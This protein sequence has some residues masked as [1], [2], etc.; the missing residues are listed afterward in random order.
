[1]R[2]SLIPRWSN[3]TCDCGLESAN[4]RF[5]RYPLH[6]DRRNLSSSSKK[7]VGWKTAWATLSIFGE[8]TRS[9]STRHDKLVGLQMDEQF[10][11][12]RVARDS[13]EYGPSSS[14]RFKDARW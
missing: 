8:R 6:C 13:P 5:V 9:R 14:I 7:V 11:S 2:P 12:F 3:Q 1:M 10:T 4:F